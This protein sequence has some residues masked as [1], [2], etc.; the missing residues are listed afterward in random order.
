MFVQNKYCA[1][2]V[3]TACGALMH[4]CRLMEAARIVRGSEMLHIDNAP[5]PP[6]VPNLEHHIA[7]WGDI[8]DRALPVF[9]ARLRPFTK[10]AFSVMYSIVSLETSEEQVVVPEPA[11]VE[12][13]WEAV[14]AVMEASLKMLFDLFEVM[15]D[16][17]QG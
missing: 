12:I 7:M 2:S 16:F 13:M 11:A 9:K 10:L 4:W 1:L 8:F 17:V 3:F 15:T 5:L 6:K 14:I